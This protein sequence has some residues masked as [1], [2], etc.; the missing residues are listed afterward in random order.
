MKGFLNFKQ[1][2]QS[3]RADFHTD[4]IAAQTVYK[5]KGG[6]T[7]PIHDGVSRYWSSHL[8]PPNQIQ[9]YI[10]LMRLDS[11]APL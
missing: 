11:I 3:N 9:P 6:A 7:S 2:A 5:G 8:G 4:R 10:G 1:T